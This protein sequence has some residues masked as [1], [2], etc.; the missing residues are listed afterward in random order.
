MDELVVVGRDELGLCP[1]CGNQPDFHF[2]DDLWH[3][4]HCG[5]VKSSEN[6]QQLVIDW[7]C[8]AALWPIASLRF[9]VM[10]R[11]MWSGSDVQRWLDEQG[12]LCRV[13]VPKV[14]KVSHET[15][16]TQPGIDSE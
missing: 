7:N 13:F 8:R 1:F 3:L 14:G 6:R 4:G 15:L 12:P 16:L 5:F 2:R 9:P 10:L 11:K